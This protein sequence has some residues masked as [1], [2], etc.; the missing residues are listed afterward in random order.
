[1]TLPSNSKT[2]GNTASKYTVRLGQ[3]LAFNSDWEVAIVEFCYPYTWK[4]LGTVE[5]QTIEVELHD[6]RVFVTTMPR[7]QYKNIVEL[8]KGVRDS[9]ARFAFRAPRT[10]RATGDAG[11]VAAELGG[12]AKQATVPP[13]PTTPR[14]LPPVMLP[15]T[16]QQQLLDEKSIESL[17]SI[18]YVSEAGW[19]VYTAKPAVKQTTLSSQLAHMLGFTDKAL[20]GSGIIALSP[21]DLKGAVDSLYIYSS[22]IRPQLIG[23]TCAPLLRV[24]S[25]KG[26]PNDIVE[27]VFVSPYYCELLT[28]SIR[29]IDIE[30]RTGGGHLVPFELGTVRCVLHFRKRNPF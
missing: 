2:L 9:L 19:F 27:D 21:I 3:E 16:P 12:N 30:V 13:P 1:M 22:I 28:K 23:D 14:A 4:T 29:E 24:C 7:A 10:T 20:S 11:K 18:H 5:D 25:V 26:L 8:E 17:I 6:G 15:A